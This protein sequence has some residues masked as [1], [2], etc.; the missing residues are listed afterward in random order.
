MNIAAQFVFSVGFGVLYFEMAGA[1]LP[2]AA[3]FIGGLAFVVYLISFY[4]PPLL[5]RF[6]LQQDAP[7]VLRQLSRRWAIGAALVLLLN[8]LV[9]LFLL[10]GRRNPVPAAMEIYMATLLGLV[11]FHALGG[12]MGEQANYLQRTAQYN[13]NQLF[14]VVVVL[15]VTFLVLTM[16]LLAF[17]LGKERAPR[18][19][20]R[21]IIWFSQS[22]LGF[23]FLIYRLAHH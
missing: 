6:T 23:G 3:P 12:L 11:I 22:L 8:V 4:L 2:D 10:T 14:I 1:F 20:V 7:H 5:F 18:I 17:D 13:S 16:Y 19:Y 15:A 9:A 21:D